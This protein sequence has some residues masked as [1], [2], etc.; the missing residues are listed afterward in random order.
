[1]FLLIHSSDQAIVL[2]AGFGAPEANSAGNA[3]QRRAWLFALQRD[4]SRC[5]PATIEVQVVSTCCGKIIHI[6]EASHG[7][8][9]SILFLLVLN[10]WEWGCWDDY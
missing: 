4:V 9:G 2:I 10:G 3:W 8:G 6:F 7:I 1:L 5:C